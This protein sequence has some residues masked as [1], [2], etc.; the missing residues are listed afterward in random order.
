M[1][2]N[3][4][5]QKERTKRRRKKK[6][7]KRK[8]TNE[9]RPRR[10]LTKEKHDAILRKSTARRSWISA[11]MSPTRENKLSNYII[12]LRRFMTHDT[13]S[14]Q[15]F[16]RASSLLTACQLFGGWG[17]GYSPI[18]I[19]HYLSVCLSLSLQLSPSV[20]LSLY[21]RFSIC[22]LFVM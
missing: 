8:E 6:T 5:K 2:N 17:G 1:K 7:G 12:S 4:D 18:N 22:E 21:I 19:Q 10:K 3:A 16:L 20:Y 9:G 14:R 15:D 13:L 11:P